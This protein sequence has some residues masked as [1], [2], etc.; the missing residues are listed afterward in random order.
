MASFTE[1]VNRTGRGDRRS[2][3][4]AGP[5]QAP[6]SYPRPMDYADVAE[7]F[8]A[9]KFPTTTIAVMG[10]SSATGTRTRTSDIDLLLI[11]DDQFADSPSGH[12]VHEF[13][14]EI[15][16]AFGYTPAGFDHWAG[17]GIAKGRPTIVH[18]LVD[19]IGI[20]GGRELEVLQHSW[21]D[22]LEAGPAVSP[23][24]LERRRYLITNLLDDLRDVGDPLER[25]VIA[26]DLFTQTAELMLLTGQRWIGTG[27]YLPR[28][29]REM[30]SS[31]AERLSQPLLRG[32]FA[33]FG[34]QV[35]RELT[36]AG[37]RM[38]A[39]FVR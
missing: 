19:G 15:F 39:G 38:L 9:T 20:R 10:G 1:P 27:K 31:R 26:A 29:L 32:D 4:S 2:G 28:R 18:I 14:G 30:S 13:E 6:V 34:D 21:Q 11:G 12:S 36:L 3:P 22:V 35:E 37:G 8:I 16:E 33:A 25:Q 24:D 17:R 7:R 5:G 23:N